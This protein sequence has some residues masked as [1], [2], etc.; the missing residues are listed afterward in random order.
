MVEPNKIIRTNRR[1]LSLVIAKDGSLVV[2]APK[3][4]S[5]QYI[6]DFIKEKEK[7]ITKKQEEIFSTVEKNRSIIQL[8]SVLYIG[9]EYEIKQIDG[10]KKPEMSNKQLYIPTIENEKKRKTYLKQWLS[11]QTK[12]IVEDRVKYFS[13]LMQLDYAAI[14]LIKSI[15]KWGTC[16]SESVLAFNYKLCML[17][18]KL[19]DYIMIHELAH[20][21]EFNHSKK[22][23]KIIE[24]VMPNWAGYRKQLK[25]Y[26]YLLTI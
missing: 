19:I 10:I 13:N 21:V 1:T 9:E 17:P 5:M 15:N 11:D 7:W 16:S 23:Y 25:N 8:R 4:V 2:H 24:S 12:A 26:S 18:P 22:F 14:K 3:R 6:L 20:L